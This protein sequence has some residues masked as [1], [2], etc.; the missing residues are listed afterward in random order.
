LKIY[1]RALVYSMGT[2]KNKILIG[3]DWK[4][5]PKEIPV[6]DTF[7]EGSILID[8]YSGQKAAVKDGKVNIDSDYGIVLL[9]P[10]Y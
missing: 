2:I 5:G 9:A 6:Y 7:A 8:H 4:N 3:L 10:Q 1:S